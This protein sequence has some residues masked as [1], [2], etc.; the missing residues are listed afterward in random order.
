MDGKLE[1]IVCIKFCVNRFKDG[2]VTVEDDERSGRPSTSK[3]T[4]YFGKIQELIMKTVTEQST[5]LQ[6][7]LGLITEFARR[8]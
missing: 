1:H 5:S 7:P 4:E 2:R 6:T 3:T 8:S